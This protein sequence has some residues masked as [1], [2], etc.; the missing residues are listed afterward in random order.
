MNDDNILKQLKDALKQFSDSVEKEVEE[1]RMH[2]E[3]VANLRD[4]I[5]NDVDG[6]AYYLRDN[7]AL[8]LSAPTVIIGNVDRSG[9]LMGASGSKVVIRT[10]ELDLEATGSP[11]VGGS[12]T[13][14]AASIRN[15]AV[16][17][18][19]DGQSNVV[20]DARSEIV[21]QAH[22][23]T[24]ATAQDKG[25]FVS[26]PGAVSGITLSTDTNIQLEATPSTAIKGKDIDEQKKLLEK[27][28][29][30]LKQQCTEQKAQVEK[31]L[32]SALDILNEQ[33]DHNEDSMTLC[34][35]YSDLS[36]LQDQYRKMQAVVVSNITSYI[37]SVSALA[38][39]NHRKK[40]LDE[41]K[42][43]LPKE[44]D[45]KKQPAEAAI[46]M[47][48]EAVSIRSVDGD[49]N[50]RDTDAAR[51]DIQMPHIHVTAGDKDG[52][53]IKDSKIDINTQRFELSTGNADVKYDDKGTPSG[54]VTNDKD[55]GILI[56]SKDI[57]IQAIDQEYKD[58]ALKESAL[59]KGSKLTLR[60]EK[61]IVSNTDTEG[62]STGMI[63]LNAK[64]IR[65]AA[66]DVD[67]EKR[68]D[69][70]MAKA[71]QLQILTEKVFV[72]SNKE[73]KAAE[74]VQVAGKQVAVM[75]K[76]TAEM[77]EGEGKS[78]LTLSG[79]NVTA[80]GSAVALQ[81]NTTIQGNADIKGEAKAPKVTSDQVEAKSAFKSPNIND[82]MGAGVPGAAGKPSAK[83]KEEEGKAVKS[84][85]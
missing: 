15:I 47:N 66:Y 57:T 75:G 71:S 17:P 9:S 31:Q 42:K 46:L 38:A 50:L 53:L 37:A 24:L 21:N 12:I 26:N 65:I 64:D 77:Q 29:K 55:S 2:R 81:G 63:D 14:R 85:E 8:I 84:Q 69:V 43:Q 36:E 40:A 58:K 61:V 59:T 76:E 73:K 18:G 4:E 1:V 41:I 67:K 49:G 23:I 48:A 80:G 27:Q 51:M 33:F 32:D 72:G 30:D 62:K 44:A 5:F 52:K 34:M 35:D 3:A 7:R 19:L 83:L 22:G 74:L 70:Q 78:V 79:G 20:C 10:N 68:T 54:K 13:A 6:G 28:I 56:N 16:D 45:F 82:T 25:A 39:L 11:D 60:T